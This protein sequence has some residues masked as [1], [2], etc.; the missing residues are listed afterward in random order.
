M[1][2]FYFGVASSFLAY[3][4][5][6]RLLLIDE[7]ALTQ[8]RR[9]NPKI[10]LFPISA[11]FLIDKNSKVRVSF[12]V[13]G[14]CYAQIEPLLVEY[15]DVSQT[16]LV[17]IQFSKRLKGLGS[18]FHGSSRELAQDNC[19]VLYQDVYIDG[20]EAKLLDLTVDASIADDH[21]P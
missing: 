17:K 15:A 19:Q 16:G 21:S 1:T 12:N 6:S 20:K 5:T 3:N 13:V 9:M 18:S 14:T 8:Y 2:E 11:V 4:S 7:V 10:R